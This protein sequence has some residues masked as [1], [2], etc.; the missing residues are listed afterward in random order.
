[1]VPWIWE[2]MDECY[3]DADTIRRHRPKQDG[4]G[5]G[6]MDEYFIDPDM[7]R[8]YRPKFDG[9]GNGWMNII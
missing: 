3:V 1:M 9:Y 5:D 4:Y 2:L 8:R 6:W 7:K